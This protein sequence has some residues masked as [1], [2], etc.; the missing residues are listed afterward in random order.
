MTAEALLAEERQLRIDLQNTREQLKRSAHT[1]EI[2][3]KERRSLEEKKP[4]ELRRQVEAAEAEVA[5]LRARLKEADAKA[6]AAA[7]GGG[8]RENTPPSRPAQPAARSGTGG[9]EWATLLDGAAKV[10]LDASRA[11]A[12]LRR[13]NFRSARRAADVLAL[14]DKP[15]QP[16]VWTSQHQPALMGG[17]GGAGAAAA[18]GM[19]WVPRDRPLFGE[20]PRRDEAPLRLE[21]AQ[22]QKSP[23]QPEPEPEP[24]LSLHH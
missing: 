23:P 21:N 12:P 2:V 3:T 20:G 24:S 22:R 19:S 14:G 16:S 15:T 5:E 13:T 9:A 8:G 7:R 17:G 4:D 11:A 10:P 18:A 6:A 1:L